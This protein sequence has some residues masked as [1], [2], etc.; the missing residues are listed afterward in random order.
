MAMLRFRYSGSLIF[1][2][3]PDSMGGDLCLREV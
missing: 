2:E 1:R 3:I